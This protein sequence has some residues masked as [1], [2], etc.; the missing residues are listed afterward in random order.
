L[1]SGVKKLPFVHHETA[2]KKGQMT[3]VGDFKQE[4]QGVALAMASALATAI[5]VLGAVAMTNATAETFVARLQFAIRADVFVIIWLGAAIAN[6]ARLRFFSE[7]DIGGSSADAGSDKVRI[8]GSILQNTFEQ[9]GLAIV[10]H[11]IVA[12]TFQRSNALIVALVC[13]FAI[14][15]ILFW[16]GYRYGAKGRAFGFALTFYPTVL[17]LLTS[18]TAILFA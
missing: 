10:A 16:A 14:G 17:A 12:A 11:M 3:E 2:V 6:V 4:Q 15:R 13:L 18:A 9:V 1:L 5:L 7:P 8:A